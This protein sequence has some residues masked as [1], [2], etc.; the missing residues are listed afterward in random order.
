MT[1]QALHMLRETFN[2][3]KGSEHL[4]GSCG[5]PRDD[6]EKTN[7]KKIPHPVQDIS[8]TSFDRALYIFL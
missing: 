3:F 4:I 2:P 5:L 6:H 1:S 7:L 8:M